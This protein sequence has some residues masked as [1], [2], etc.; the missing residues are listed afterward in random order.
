MWYLVYD[1]TASTGKPKETSKPQRP[2]TGR[3]RRKVC[4]LYSLWI[5][6]PETKFDH[7]TWDLWS[8]MSTQPL[9]FLQA[10]ILEDE[11]E[12]WQAEEFCVK[13]MCEHEEVSICQGHVWTRARGGKHLLRSCVNM[14]SWA[15]VKVM[16]EQKEVSICQGHVW[17]QGGE[18]LSRS[19]VNTRR[20]AFV[21]VM[22]EHEDVSFFQ[23]H[24][25]INLCQGYMSRRWKLRSLLR[26]FVNL[27]R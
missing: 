12:D 16:C 20:W 25:N 17:T 10:V 22:C 24:V 15:F 5:P 6:Q 8:W 13:V 23:G 14:K 4:Y 1:I 11:E 27:R 21:K 9:Y 26:S 19:C 18:H 7:V 3:E 2:S